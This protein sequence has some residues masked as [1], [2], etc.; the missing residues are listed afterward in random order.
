MSTFSRAARASAWGFIATAVLTATPALAQNLTDLPSSH[1]AYSAV[2]YLRERGVLEGYSDGTFRPSQK[3]TRAE[4]VKILVAAVVQ[5]DVPAGTSGYG[6]VPAGVWYEPYV[7]YAW[8][9]LKIA[10]GPSVSGSFRGERNVQKVEFLKMLLLAYKADPASFGEIKL[11]L[12]TD[13]TDTGA[14]FYPFIRYALSAS[15]L[16]VQPDGMLSPGQELTRA[17]VAMYLHRFLTYK[18]GR[19]TQALLSAAESDLVNVLK[20]LEEKQPEQAEF[21]SARALLAARGAHAS[22]P[23]TPLVQGALK[24]TQSFRALVRAYKAGSLGAPDE[25]ITLA[26]EAW[27]LAE[28]SR[29]RSPELAGLAAQVQALAGKM[30]ESARALQSGQ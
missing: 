9:E 3:V 29:K 30:A 13:V 4:A 23:D 2:Q 11:P 5:G 10:D 19:R 14:W 22:K 25:A 18:E 1:E 15:V 16:T 8:K 20:M 7:T 6:D 26:K 27:A 17:Q 28:E 21:A 12:A 24:I